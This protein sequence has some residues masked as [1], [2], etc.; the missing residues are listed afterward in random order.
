MP[1][2]THA[3]TMLQSESGELG[4]CAALLREWR[5]GQVWCARLHSPLTHATT[6]SQSESGELGECGAPPC[7]TMAF[8]ACCCL[9]VGAFKVVGPPWTAAM[10]TSKEPDP[11][12]LSG[13][14]PCCE[15]ASLWAGGQGST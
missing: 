10:A 7:I 9:G 1:P 15:D 11:Q 6:M 12:D 5:A 4:K 13:V 8:A 2:P 3:T 14:N